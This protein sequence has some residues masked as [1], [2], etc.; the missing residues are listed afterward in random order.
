MAIWAPLA[1]LCWGSGQVLFWGPGK[2]PAMWMCPT[3]APQ[4][5]GFRS[6]HHTGH[7]S[8]WDRGRVFSGDLLKS[9]RPCSTPGACRSPSQ[10]RRSHRATCLLPVM[11][12]RSQT[13][14]VHKEPVEVCKDNAVRC[15]GVVECSQKSDE[16]D[17]GNILGSGLPWARGWGLVPLASDVL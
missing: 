5:P 8:P 3:I 10:L 13:G 15:D 6:A 12:W 11:F 9:A 4:G 1:M 16:L 2:A 7:D 17:C 14:I